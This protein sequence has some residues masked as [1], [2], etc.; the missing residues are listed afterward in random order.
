MNTEKTL[1][2][3]AEI[4]EDTAQAAAL[5]EEGQRERIAAL[6]RLVAES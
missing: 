3:L 2:A 1:P 5:I 6:L 4:E